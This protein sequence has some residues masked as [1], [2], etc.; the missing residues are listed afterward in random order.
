MAAPT[1]DDWTIG[2]QNGHLYALVNTFPDGATNAQVRWRP[3]PS[4]S[5][6]TNEA[7]SPLPG[8][9][10][11]ENITTPGDYDVEMRWNGTLP[12]QSDW[13]GPQTGSQP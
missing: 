9:F 5:W 12:T 6:T 13:S 4:G 2:L 8:Q 1:D 10:F 11:I 3:S 7:Q